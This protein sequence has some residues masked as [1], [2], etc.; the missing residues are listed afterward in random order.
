[1]H[2]SKHNNLVS[3]WAKVNR[4]REALYERPA[5]VTVNARI[6]QRVVQDGGNGLLSNRGEG[7]AESGPLA[8]IPALRIE[9]F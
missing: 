8:L 2:H 3:D 1:M 9:E 7:A 6:G 5:R 4:I